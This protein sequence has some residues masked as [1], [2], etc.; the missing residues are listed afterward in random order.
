MSLDPLFQAFARSQQAPRQDNRAAPRQ[1][2]RADRSA[3]THGGWCS[4][5][6]HEAGSC[7][8]VGSGLPRS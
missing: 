8:R 4:P 3:R 6:P 2:T 7:P 1:L 5:E